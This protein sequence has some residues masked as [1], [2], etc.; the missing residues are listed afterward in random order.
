LDNF[1]FQSGARRPHHSHV[2]W[3]NRFAFFGSSG[4][5]IGRRED[6]SSRWIFIPLIII[7]IAFAWLPPLFSWIRPARHRL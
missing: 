5:G 7:A 1:L 2:G 6:P 4:L 3:R